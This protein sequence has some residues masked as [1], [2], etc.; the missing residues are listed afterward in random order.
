MRVLIV[1]TTSMGDVI[2]TL[3]A[4]TDAK[5]ALPQVQFDWVVEDSFAEVPSWHP[6]VDMVIPVAIRRWRKHILA[7]LRSNEWKQF[8]TLLRK[9]HYD[10]VIDAQGLIKSAWVTWLTKAPAAGYD[11]ESARESLASWAYQHRYNV[12]RECHAVERIRQLFAKALDYELPAGKG[13]YGLDRKRFCG[14]T[15]EA[16]NVV[17]LHGTTWHDKHYPE[18]YWR[19]L[20]LE[21]TQRNIRVRLPWGN[22][23]EKNRA[24]RIVD[25]IEGA[26]VLPKLNLNGVAAV[27]GQASAVVAVDTGLGHLS[28]AMDVPTVSL[29][30]PTSPALV[31]AYGANQIHLC[32]SDCEPV[33]AEADP[34]VFSALTPQ[35]VLGALQP[36]LPATTTPVV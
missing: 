23:T 31:G 36:L 13:S 5:R 29:Y 27:L 3:P 18:V 35:V 21:L 20:A 6:A 2:H 25:G 30:G 10:L 14:G 24:H 8:R 32:A 12:P 22:E 1:K 4:L 19:Q 28:A 17:F 11:R 16:P 9:H 7:T 26:E 33:L 15:P 34:A